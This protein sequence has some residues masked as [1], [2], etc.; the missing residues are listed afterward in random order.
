MLLPQGVKSKS[1]NAKMNNTET[2]KKMTKATEGTKAKSN[3]Q[4]DYGNSV[5]TNSHTTINKERIE[6]K[7]YTKYI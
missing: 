7:I 4:T 1:L 3:T 2:A 6:E 5:Q